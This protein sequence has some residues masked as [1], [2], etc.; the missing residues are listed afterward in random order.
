MLTQADRPVPR[1][2]LGNRGLRVSAP[3]LGC[4]G[5]SHASG[6]PDDTES[7]QV[8][9]RAL[10]LGVTFWDTADFYGQG[11]NESLLARALQTRRSEVTL[12]TKFGI[13]ASQGETLAADVRGDAAT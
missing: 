4:M 12:A 11:A 2:A 1:V 13:V 5:M 3:G 10:E 7:L 8:L 9:E 6:A